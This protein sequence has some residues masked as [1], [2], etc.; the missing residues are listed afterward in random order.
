MQKNNTLCVFWKNTQ[1]F[2]KIT[3]GVDVENFDFFD[4]ILVL[5]YR[6]LDLLIERDLLLFRVFIIV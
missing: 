5:I 1:E 2:L 3:L 6:L 4:Q